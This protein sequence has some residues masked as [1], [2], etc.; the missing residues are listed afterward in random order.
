VMRA[1]APRGMMQPEQVAETVAFVA[2]RQAS[3]LHGA[4]IMADN[5]K[6]IG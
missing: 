4:V 1:S 2:S 5:G 6:T 3:A